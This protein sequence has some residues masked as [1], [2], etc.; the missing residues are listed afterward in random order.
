MTMRKPPLLL[1]AFLCLPLISCNSQIQEFV[2]VY[3]EGRVVNT[4][5]GQAVAN[6]KIIVES[7]KNYYEYSDKNGLFKLTF[8][9]RLGEVTDIIAHKKGYEIYSKPYQNVTN[10]DHSEFGHFKMEPDKLLITE[11]QD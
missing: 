7:K 8:N 6:A 1:I 5:T 2:T 4:E 3:I 11:A 10:I 9:M